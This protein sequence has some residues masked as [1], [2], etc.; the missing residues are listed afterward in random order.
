MRAGQTAPLYVHM[1]VCMHACISLATPPTCHFSVP[2]GLISISVTTA[3]IHSV[4]PPIMFALEQRPLNVE[5]LAGSLLWSVYL[6]HR[7]ISS[8]STVVKK[9][10]TIA[11]KLEREL[12]AA[13][14]K[15]VSLRQSMQRAD[16]VLNHILKNTITEGIGCIDMFLQKLDKD[17]TDRTALTELLTQVPHLLVPS[18]CTMSVQLG[19]TVRVTGLERAQ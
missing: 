9:L 5:V 17:T 13:L 11:A 16:S 2:A 3:V 4:L 19:V 7:S 18:P 12:A 15:E 14:E 6:V 10:Q 8:Y 1:H